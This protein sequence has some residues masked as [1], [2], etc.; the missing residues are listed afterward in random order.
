MIWQPNVRRARQEECPRRGIG[1]M[2]RSTDGSDRRRVVYIL[3]IIFRFI[4]RDV[5]WMRP[6][7]Q[8][9]CCYRLDCLMN[10][11]GKYMDTFLVSNLKRCLAD[12]SLHVPL[13][14]IKSCQDNT[15]VLLGKPV[16]D[17]GDVKV[18]KS[19]LRDK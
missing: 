3:W 1:Y 16:R 13:D 15:L 2:V 10:L 18:G 5:E 6:L 12:A 8:G 4:G 11:S 14:E 9:S 7:H 19:L 17:Y